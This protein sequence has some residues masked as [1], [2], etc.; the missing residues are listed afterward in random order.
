[1][2]D[3]G[4]KIPLLQKSGSSRSKLK[5]VFSVIKTRAFIEMRKLGQDNNPD[6][7]YRYNI[8]VSNQEIGD[9][10]RKIVGPGD[11]LTNP[12][13]ISKNQ[14]PAMLIRPVKEVS[15]SFGRRGGLVQNFYMNKKGR[16][17]TQVHALVEKGEYLPD[18]AS[19]V[20]WEK[21]EKGNEAGNE[22]MDVFRRESWNS[23]ELSQGEIAEKKN[24]RLNFKEK[25]VVQCYG[26][27]KLKVSEKISILF[28]ESYYSNLTPVK[29]LKEALSDAES[30]KR[31][32]AYIERLS[33]IEQRRLGEISSYF[34]KMYPTL[35]ESIS[36]CFTSVSLMKKSREFAIFCEEYCLTNMDKLCENRY[37]L[38]AMQTLAEYSPDFS[39]RFIQYFYQNR[40]KLM[41][42]PDPVLLLNKAILGAKTQNLLDFLID[43]LSDLFLFKRKVQES[44]LIRVIPNLLVRCTDK[45]LLHILEVILPRVTWLADEKFGWYTILALFEEKFLPFHR[46][47]TESL[48]S[49]PVLMM[50]RKNRKFILAKLL[51]MEVAIPFHCELVERLTISNVTYVL[52]S[53]AR[54]E[55]SI[56][57]LLGV[58][59]TAT[60]TEKVDQNLNRLLRGVDSDIRL[61]QPAVVMLKKGLST[62]KRFI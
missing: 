20:E 13:T 48:L 56:S 40:E 11:V 53:V 43:E 8:R 1:M 7:N 62:L 23:K 6:S 5:E 55:I 54:C 42:A 31:I 24:S 18:I 37:A 57:L 36:G 51:R 30:S 34:K 52:K 58:L 16:F 17:V 3:S 21:S 60:N 49:D 47:L 29:L 46:R 35:I 14:S 22:E 50:T 59:A 25:M 33:E 32:Q 39:S 61:N 44:E 4:F 45:R 27:L 10:T 15:G 9:E 2:M 26:L 28:D 12:S 41:F 38:K 19:L